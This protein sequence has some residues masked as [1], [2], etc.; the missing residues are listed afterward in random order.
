MGL[1]SNKRK[2]PWTVI[3]GLL[4][5][6]IFYLS[7]S[8]G[9]A[10][11]QTVKKG[12]SLERKKA[13]EDSLR[14]AQQFEIIKYWSSG[15]EYYKNKSYG[16]AQKYFWKVIRMDTAMAYADT[17]HYKD[18][19]AR[20]AN[21]YVRQNKPDSAQI[22][23][24]M[25]LK[26]FPNDIYLHESLGY[27]LRSKGQLEASAKQYEKAVQLNPKKTVDWKILAEIYVKLRETDKAIN[28]YEKYTA[29][30]PNDRKALEILSILY[31]ESGEE[32]KAIAKKE[33]ILKNNPNDVDLM[34]QLGK[35]YG[36]LGNYQKARDL[37][38]RILK[39][40]PENKI[41]LSLLAFSYM[42]LEAYTEAIQTYKKLMK[43]EPRNAEM[44]CNI[45]SAYRMKKN[46]RIAKN[47]V[48]KAISID[49]KY[50]LVYI[51]MAQIYEASAADCINQKG[52]KVDFDDKL[53]YEKA[54]NE[55]KKA[56][57]DPA[58]ITL[59]QQ[60]MDAIRAMLPTKQDRF[61]NQ[62]KKE[63]TSPCYKWIF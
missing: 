48:R 52:G 49:P 51:T 12:M 19:F 21:C 36:D 31:K 15:Y 56:L 46:Y 1:I 30:K 62:G 24:K 39:L 57:K 61:F 47:Y 33:E 6:I 60:R 17:F 55:Y 20:L 43:L 25:G 23:Y 4:T 58:Y 59:A 16:D 35:T 28:A 50:G 2:T 29:L 9:C 38:L 7:I 34:L 27:M 18:I 40:E 41:A 11:Q 45:A 63:P 37:Y 42:N 54:Y 8:W 5:A 26:Y 44:L 53:V 13:I 32:E 22:V 3:V 10:P 14:K